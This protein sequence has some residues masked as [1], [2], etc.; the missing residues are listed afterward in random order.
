MQ[1]ID[2]HAHLDFESYDND[3]KEVI[4]RA[5]A[6]GVFKI[7]NIG[8]S[9]AGCKKGIE[10]AGEYENIYTTLGIHPE[11][12]A[13]L[14]EKTLKFFRANIKN[15]KVIGIGEIGLDNYV[16]N[17]P[18]DQQKAVFVKQLDFATENNLLVVIHIRDAFADVM[19]IL[20]KYD[21][22]KN[23]GVI[24][25]Y[26][27][28]YKK[29]KGILDLGLYLSFT[30]IVTY[31]EGTQKAALEVPLDRMMLE[32]DSPFLAPEPDRGERAEPRHVLEVAKKIAEIKGLTLEEVAEKTTQTAV[33]FFNLL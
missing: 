21:W 13:E 2:T 17:F 14:N 1:L 20:A 12:A 15:S 5:Q 10:L 24:H 26:S 32:T 33:T 6:A 28:S 29:V 11:E 8:A 3:R 25:C 4:E 18:L 16:K 30:G 31:D 9:L 22:H 7:I 23:K 19:D 27:S